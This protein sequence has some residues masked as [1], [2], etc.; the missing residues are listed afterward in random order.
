MHPDARLLGQQ[1][2][3]EVTEISEF[4]PIIVK[5]MMMFSTSK[6]VIVQSLNSF[7]PDVFSTKVNNDVLLH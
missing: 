6:L 5:I 3:L 4:K 2:Q 7:K 1:Q